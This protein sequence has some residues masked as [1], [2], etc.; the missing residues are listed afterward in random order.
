VISWEQVVTKGLRALRLESIRSKILVFAVLATLIPSL[1]TAWISYLQNKRALTEKISQELQTASTQTSNAMDLWLKS[2]IYNLRVFSLSYEVAGN[3]ANL[4]H[5][6]Q[7][8]RRVN[9][10]LASVRVRFADYEALVVLDPQTRIVAGNARSGEVPLPSDWATQIRNDN[11][12]VGDPYPDAT[13]KAVMVLAYP[14][15]SANG[16][17]LGTLAVRLNLHALEEPMKRFAPRAPGR[18]YFLTGTGALIGAHRVDGVEPLK[19]TLPLRTV[20]RLAG[21]QGAA[22]EYRS[23]DGTRVVGTLEHLSPLRWTVMVETPTADAFQQVARLRNMT[24]LILTVLLLVLGLLGYLLGLLIVRPLN[25]LTRGAAAVAAGNLEVD[26][27]VIG[28]GEVGYLTEVFNNMVARLRDSHR[29]L[30]RLSVTDGLTGLYNRRHL[31][32]T[33]GNEVRRSLRLKHTFAVLMADVDLFKHYND[34]NGHLAGD[35]VLRRLAAILR[36]TCR[37]VDTAAR[38][39]GEEFL[40]LLPETTARAAADV[41]ERLRQRLAGETFSGGTITLSIGVAEFPEHGDTP[42]ALIAAAD[43]ALYGAKHDGRDRVVRAAA[44]RRSKETKGG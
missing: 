15:R 28:G 9:D 12:V 16:R 31:M 25:R 38:Y 44:R 13:G 30:E 18:V 32:D 26:L 27:P 10:Y 22:E 3:L 21:L 4:G 7:P 34:T 23:I 29:E 41:A 2:N 8:L 20:Q 5:G 33:L 36:E 37:E 14:L 11:Q 39:G 43:V 17:M 24:G 6:G 40:V 19:S 42:E 35:E 1:S